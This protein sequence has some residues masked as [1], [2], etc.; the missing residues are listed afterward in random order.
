VGDARTP[1][2]LDPLLLAAVVDYETRPGG[3]DAEEDKP[4]ARRKFGAEFPEACVWIG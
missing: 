1:I 2:C 3:D 4:V